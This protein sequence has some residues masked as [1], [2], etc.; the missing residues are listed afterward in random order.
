MQTPLPARPSLEQ[1]KKLAKDLVKGHQE[2]K[3]E[4]FKLI[5]D[6]LPALSGKSE[7]EISSYSF[8]LHDA[9]SVIARQHGFP[10]WKELQAYVEA[11]QQSEGSK[12]EPPAEVAEKL[13]VVLKAREQNDYALF[14]TAV[15]PQFQALVSKERFDGTERM[16]VYFKAD[17]HLTYM[18]KLIQASRPVYFWR[19]WVEGWDSDI[20][21]RM[22]LNDAGLI[23]GLLYSAPFDTAMGVKK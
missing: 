15:S 20:L 18:G 19:L 6:F 13:A 23:S 21:I 2:K 4:A 9:Q 12:L 3:P 1:L 11:S 16:S 14:C 7:Q 10:G 22:S 5:R 8:A 17:Y